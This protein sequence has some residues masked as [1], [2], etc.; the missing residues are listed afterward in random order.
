MAC[1]AHSPGAM[2]LYRGR[3]AITASYHLNYLLVA[4]LVVNGTEWS[5]NFS[6]RLS[7]FIWDSDRCEWLMTTHANYHTSM[8]STACTPAPS[9]RSAATGLSSHTPL[10]HAL[11]LGWVF[12]HLVCINA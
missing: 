8:E 7:T 2:H 12:L 1:F 6:P 5:N 10:L 4:G 9:P 11:L 3:S